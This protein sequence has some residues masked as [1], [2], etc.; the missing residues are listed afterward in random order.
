MTPPHL[1]AQ[2]T[3]LLSCEGDLEAIQNILRR[4][5]WSPAEWCTD[6]R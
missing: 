3:R 5:E 2:P 1:Q 6:P 4:E